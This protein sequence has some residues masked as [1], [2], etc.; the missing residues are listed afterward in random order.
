MEHSIH[1]SEAATC[2]Q[3]QNKILAGAK[4][5]DMGCVQSWRYLLIQKL[6]GIY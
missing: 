4:D 1:V 3:L 6:I 5:V 2:V